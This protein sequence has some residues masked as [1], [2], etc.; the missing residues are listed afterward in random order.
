MLPYVLFVIASPSL[1]VI[2]SR[3]RRISPPLRVNSAW[4]SPCPSEIA[5]ADEISLAMTG[6]GRLLATAPSVV[7]Y[8]SPYK[9]ANQGDQQHYCRD[10]GGNE[11]P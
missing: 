10:Y 5:S 11:S 4:Q 1:L 9:K 8:S 2:L 6:G 7:I 3:R